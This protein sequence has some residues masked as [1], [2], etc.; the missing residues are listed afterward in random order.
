MH[1]HYPQLNS[2]SISELARP[3]PGG[4]SVSDDA[5][6]YIMIP[7]IHHAA[8]LALNVFQIDQIAINSAPGARV[9]TA[10]CT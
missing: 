9:V 4:R 3:R 7:L 10:A 8:I 2:K 5:S 6:A 1:T